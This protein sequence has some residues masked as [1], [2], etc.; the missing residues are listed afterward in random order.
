MYDWQKR[1]KKQIEEKLGRRKQNEFAVSIGMEPAYLKHKLS[2]RRKA[3]EKDI[4]RIASGLHM[5][6][7]KLIAD[8]NRS[9]IIE[10]GQDEYA[11][12]L[13]IVRELTDLYVEK[14]Q[15]KKLKELQKLLSSEQLKLDK[16]IADN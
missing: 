14:K 15:V 11:D 4:K 6:P 2:G 16:I 10:K 5:L 8:P 9:I 12:L 3:T 13:R 1:A 7:E